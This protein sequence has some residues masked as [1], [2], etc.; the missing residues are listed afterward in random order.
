M[1]EL[2]EENVERYGSEFTKLAY[3]LGLDVEGTFA[4]DVSEHDILAYLGDI[5]YNIMDQVPTDE[6]VAWSAI[7]NPVPVFSLE[8]LQLATKYRNIIPEEFKHSFYKCKRIPI[9]PYSCMGESYYTLEMCFSRDKY[10]DV[11]LLL[12]RWS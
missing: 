8:D 5:S 11:H 6:E 12:K 7:V 4:R 10:E 1:I 2:T 3:R 9:D